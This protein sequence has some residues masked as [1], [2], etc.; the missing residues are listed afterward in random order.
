M[1]R[2][3]STNL[4]KKLQESKMSNPYILP[5]EHD[6]WIKTPRRRLLLSS[7]EEIEAKYDAKAER[8]VTE[9]NREKLV[10][11][12]ESLKRPNYMD[13]RPFYQRRQRWT[14]DRQS[15]LIESFLINIPIPPLFV[16]ESRPNV[17]E[18]MDGQQRIT[19]I[20]AFYDSRLTLEGLERWPE[21][22]GRTYAT[23]PDRIRA[24]I[25][26][27]SISWVTVL[28][29]SSENE[30]D[31]FSIKQL[32]FE[33]LN[34]GGVKL[35]AQEIRN[36][37]FAGDFNDALIKMSRLDSHRS[38]WGL[39]KYSE[40]E[41]RQVPINL[42]DSGFYLEMEDVEVILRF[43]ALRHAEHYSRG[44][45]EFLDFYMQK[46]RSLSP[47]EIEEL[48]RLYE[49]VV[50]LAA[51]IYGDLAFKPYVQ[52]KL[53]GKWNWGTRKQ[54]AYA[55]AVLVA[56]SE[57]LGNGSE[58]IVQRENLLELTKQYFQEDREGVLVGRGNTKKDV[59]ARIDRLREIFKKVLAAADADF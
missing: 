41:E 30:E 25:D 10:N 32:V 50:E 49:A 40:I 22:N 23:L 5:A 53:S 31:A 38:V 39:P 28:S 11:F 3:V 52:D 45:R 26:R 16:Y 46:A 19:A 27:R 24:G 55:D 9:T 44:M 37:L 7:D 13:P 56:L 14:A 33:R 21:L 48:E 59:L 8:I 54:K 34:T 36:A 35:S 15:Q 18:V 20:K 58:L 2:F 17:Y 12:Y 57:Q 43:F 51:E 4:A 29:E 1:T 42:A 47:H 6:F